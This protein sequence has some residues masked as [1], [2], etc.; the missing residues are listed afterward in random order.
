MRPVP[1][2]TRF[3]VA[4]EGDSEYS[5]A[6]FLQRLADQLGLHIYLDRSIG[7]GGDPLATVEQAVEDL[8]KGLR[9]GSY[10]GRFVLLDADLIGRDPNRDQKMRNLCARWQLDLILQD[11]DHEAVL[12]RHYNGHQTRRPPAGSAETELRRVWQGY[13]KPMAADDLLKQFGI[14]DVR[15]VAGVE[16]DFQRMFRALGLI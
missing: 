15:R 8:R 7:G 12:L 5:Y 16:P 6:L 4:G 13:S 14:T 3:F 1:Q 10:R 2:R 9:R 11:C